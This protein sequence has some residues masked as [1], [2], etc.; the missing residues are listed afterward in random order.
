M[1]AT[2]RQIADQCGVSRQTVTNYLKKLGLWEDHVTK[3]EIGQASIVD[4]YAASAVVAQIGIRVTSELPA[5]DDTDSGDGSACPQIAGMSEVDATAFGGAWRELCDS[6]RQHNADL[7]AQIDKL[8]DELDAKDATYQEALE[9]KDQRISE[10]SAQLTSSLATIKA[11]PSA[12][13]VDDAKR[14]GEKGEREKIA[15]M[16]FFQRRRYLKG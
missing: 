14:A 3:G 5:N 12:D 1:P 8:K 10:L 6:L 16:G 9:R 7:E 4:D 11:L 15:S 2:L 13:A